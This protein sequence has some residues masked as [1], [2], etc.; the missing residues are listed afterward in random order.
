LIFILASTA[1]VGLKVNRND[2]LINTLTEF[3]QSSLDN[4]SSHP[5]DWSEN[6]NKL[7]PYPEQDYGEGYDKGDEF[8]QADASAAQTDYNGDYW[9]PN[10]QHETQDGYPEEG[11]DHYPD[12]QHETDPTAPLDNFLHDDNLWYTFATEDSH[13]YYLESAT[14]HTQWEDPRIYGLITYSDDHGLTEEEFSAGN[15]LGNINSITLSPSRRSHQVTPKK[16]P[17]PPNKV[18]PDRRISPAAKEFHKPRSVPLSPIKNGVDSISVNSPIPSRTR[19]K[20]LPPPLAESA[21]DEDVD[22]IL[23][24]VSERHNGLHRKDHHITSSSISPDAYAHS[25]PEKAIPGPSLNLLTPPESNQKKSK[26]RIIVVDSDT[27]SPHYRNSPK[28]QARNEPP[29]LPPEEYK[30]NCFSPNRSASQRAKSLQKKAPFPLSSP[31]PALRVAAIKAAALESTV[32]DKGSVVDNPPTNNTWADS[33]DASPGSHRSPVP[34][35][36]WTRVVMK[37]PP[38]T[39]S[40]DCDASFDDEEV[41]EFSDW[42]DDDHQQQ[43]QQQRQKEIKKANQTLSAKSHGRKGQTREDTVDGIAQD[44]IFDSMDG[45]YGFGGNRFISL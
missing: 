5:E 41:E 20:P 7:E 32:R 19:N 14:Q 2:D 26:R 30:T 9:D 8:Y 24:R 10:Q 38:K 40:D 36:N 23:R 44:K 3:D 12:Y 34:M 18:T 1:T 29:L 42:D 28:T 21:D 27:E 17:R 13:M 37:T 45:A 22:A 25:P 43:R 15:E 31:P 39:T 6:W 35:R 33:H 11:D 4:P 16:S